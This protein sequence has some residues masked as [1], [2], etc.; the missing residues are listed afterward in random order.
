MIPANAISP[1]GFDID[2]LSGRPRVPVLAHAAEPPPL[3]QFATLR[4][5]PPS[6]PY[7]GSGIAAA[8]RAPAGPLAGVHMAT[9]AA[10]RKLADASGPA[11][12]AAQEFEAMM[13][14]QMFQH[15]F[16]GIKSGGPFG[17]GHAEAVYRSFLL[18]AYGESVAE[19]GG[20]G[21]ASAVYKDIARSYPPV[22]G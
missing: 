6:A 15:M 4:P 12:K 18:Q 2:R 13:L 8:F 19:Q 21:I 20:I 5:A 14:A 10:E 9:R 11:W 1:P 3:A 16:A 7:P 22:E 17:G